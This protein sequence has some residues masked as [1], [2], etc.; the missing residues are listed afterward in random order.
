[1]VQEMMEQ[2]GDPLA[3]NSTRHVWYFD[4]VRIRLGYAER[5][6][7]VFQYQSAQFDT[8]LPDE[9]TQWPDERIYEYLISRV[10]TTR[11]GQRCRVIATT[12]P[13]NVGGQWVKRRWAAWLDRNHPRPAAPGEL[14]WYKRDEDGHEVECDADDPDGLSRT[15]IPATLESN[16]HI[17]ADYRKR[18]MALPEPWRSQLLNGDWTA[19]EADDPWQLIPTAWVDAAMDRWKK[20]T[21]KPDALGVDVA[22]GGSDDTALAPRMGRV[23]DELQSTPG[24][25][26]PDGPAVAALVVNACPPDA[27][28]G[29]DIIGVGTSP[30]DIL[31]A[32]GFNVIPLNGAAKAMRIEYGVEKPYTDRSGQLSMRNLRAGICWNLR[33]LLEDG[34]ID[35]PPD[36]ELRAELIALRWKITPAGVQVESKEDAKK[37]TGLGFHKSDSVGYAC[38]VQ[39]TAPPLSLSQ[40]PSGFYSQASK[41]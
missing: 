14:R 25:L 37:R 26:T 5:L 7:D 35:L 13:G 23:I 16:P 38:W 22:R 36:P 28:I 34:E 18:L 11:K 20:P 39:H 29:L 6:A 41:D 2:Y 9:L 17:D 31:K 24:K 19:D 27:M 8:L 30:Y 40:L 33:E 21:D 10:R 32:Q 3:Y 12:N 15:F 4:D 1:M